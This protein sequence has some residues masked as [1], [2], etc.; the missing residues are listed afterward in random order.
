MFKSILILPD[1]K[2]L[3][4]EIPDE[5][6]KIL[7]R[8]YKKYGNVNEHKLNELLHS[9]GSPLCA[10]RSPIILAFIMKNNIT[11]K[12]EKLVNWYMDFLSYY[13]ENEK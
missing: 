12:D 5:R 3:G 4:K 1:E 7:F 2:K 6:K 13:E 9:N 8:V 11:F 10:D